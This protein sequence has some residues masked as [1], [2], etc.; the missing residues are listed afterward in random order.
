MSYSTDISNSLTETLT[1]FI[2][3]ERHQFAGHVANL[4]FWLQEVKHCIKINEDYKKRFEVMKSAQMQY[5][6]KHFH[7]APPPRSVPDKEIKEVLQALC[8][9]AYSFIIHCYKEGFIEEA[10][11][12]KAADY[13]GVSI[14][15]RDLNR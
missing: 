3:L 10:K 6:A 5:L 2:T 9:T 4:D 14:D 15:T 1:K 12:R 11:L 7:S 8:D 13:I